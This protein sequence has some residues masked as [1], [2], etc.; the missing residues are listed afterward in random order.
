MAEITIL[1]RGTEAKCYVDIKSG[2][3]C[4]TRLASSDC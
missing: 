4:L 3:L 1:R 2:S